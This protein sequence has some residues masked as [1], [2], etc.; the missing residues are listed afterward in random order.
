MGASIGVAIARNLIGQQRDGSDAAVLVEAYTLNSRVISTTGDVDITADASQNIRALTFAGSAA[1]AVG[2]TGVA[3]SG[4]GVYNENIINVSVLAA[5]DGDF[6]TGTEATV[7]G[8]AVTVEATN[9]SAIEAFAGAA[10]IA[11]AVGSTGVA[12][13]I[14]LGLA[15]N[16]IL[17]TVEARIQN[18]DNDANDGVRARTGNVEVLASD[19]ADIAVTAA[20]ASISAAFGSTS[21]AVSG[22]GAEATNRINST[23][24]AHISG[25]DV[26][27]PMGDVNVKAE[28]D[29]DIRATVVAASAAIAV[30]STGIGAS[31]GVAVVRNLIGYDQTAF[32][33]SNNTGQSVSQLTKNATTVEILDGARKGDVYKYVGETVVQAD[34]V[35]NE[36]GDTAPYALN[37]QDYANTDL[38]ELI[39]L[40]EERAIIDASI[41]A[42]SDVDAGG[43]VL[44]DARSAQQIK[45]TTIAGSVAVAGGQVGVAVSGSGAGVENR[46]AT[47]VK[48]HISGAGTTVDASTI[49]VN[50]D[51][52]SQIDSVSLAFSVSAAF[53]QTGVA[54]ALGVSIAFNTVET[55]VAAY[56]DTGASATSSGVDALGNGVTISAS[57]PELPIGTI[58]TDP[59]VGAAWALT[60][61]DQPDEDFDDTAAGALDDA[62]STYVEE[63]D[64]MLST[65][66]QADINSDAV[67]LGSLK[68]QLQSHFEIVGDLRITVVEELKGWTLVDDDGNS[69]NLRLENGT[70]RVERA[71]INSV[72]IAASLAVAGGQIGVGIS[73]AGAYSQNVIKSN[74]AAY[75]DGGTI[76]A[77]GGGDVLIDARAESEINAIVVAV[78]ASVAVGQ[79]GVGV[80][81][82]ISVAEN[83]IGLDEDGTEALGTGQVSAYIK[84]GSADAEGDLSIIADSRQTIRSA[85]IAGAVAI[86]GGQV[87]VA[88][89]GTGVYALNAI[90]ATTQAY[91][92]GDGATGVRADRVLVAATDTSDIDTVAAAISISAGF[93]MVGVAVSAGIAIAENTI[94]SD[95]LAE[96]RN[97]DTA[98][99]GR[100]G[101]VEVLASNSATITSTTAAAAVAISAGLV[102]VSF[103]LAGATANNL[104]ESTTTAS[105]DESTVTTTG[106]APADLEELGDIRVMSDSDVTIDALV[107]AASVAFRRRRCGLR[108]FGRVLARYEHDREWRHQ[109]RLCQ[110]RQQHDHR[111]QRRQGRCQDGRRDDR[112]QRRGHRGRDRHW[113]GGGRGLRHRRRCVQQARLRG[114]LRDHRQ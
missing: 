88:V 57:T 19:E 74:V 64:D 69:F 72:S 24:K 62:A 105:I 20:A 27:A 78:A 31:I 106:A 7:E 83:T 16:K 38:W 29:G 102:G 113:R 99:E 12:V 51:D 107:I 30:G 14:G 95:T 61:G 89:A 18:A 110:D 37:S 45:A 10:S 79:V 35:I 86:A 28:A 33:A 80:G 11:A 85:T 50:A 59:S 15:Q 111:V 36:A 52:V 23:T 25:S 90:N 81:I 84:N 13:S 96:I 87:G 39:N 48:A 3:V 42:G 108:R 63:D 73:G 6:A 91:I 21:V 103:S 98:V 101:D 65:L 8:N 32:T 56:I 58:L 68:T 43:G 77:N 49:T 9:A 41:G 40:G 26:D 22:A 60:A 97:A 44:V 4:S 75:L 67:V 46:I 92:D 2:S 1:V 94:T 47:D 17:G 93:G 82:G 114:D 53:G 100:A 5:I 55:N 71:T 76:D 112:R 54:V 104:I 34:N 109:R 70:F 66:E